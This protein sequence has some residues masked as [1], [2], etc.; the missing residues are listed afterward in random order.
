MSDEHGA[1]DGSLLPKGYSAADDYAQQAWAEAQAA[2]QVDWERRLLRRGGKDEG[3]IETA[4]QNAYLILRYDKAWQG[5]IALDEF[6]QRTIK[7]RPP[8]YE[9]AG[10]GEW[11][12]IDDSRTRVWL[13]ERYRVDFPTTTVAE[14]VSVVGFHNQFHPVREY[15]DGCVERWDGAEGRLDFWLSAYLGVAPPSCSTP[16]QRQYMQ[17]VGR[18]W[19]LSAVARIYQPGCKADHVLILEGPQGL[20][21]SSALRTLFGSWFLDT[22]INLND[23]DAYQAVQGRWGVELAELDSLN[24]VDATRAKSFFSSSEDYFRPSYGRRAQ[25]FPR[26]CVFAGSTNQNEYL[27]DSTGN[28]RFWPVLC[29][30]IDLGELERDRDHLWAEA[31]LAYRADASWWPEPAD[32]ALF[33]RE[34]ELREI[35]DPWTAVLAAWLESCT[36]SRVTMRECFEE[37]SI[38]PERQDER[39]MAMRIGKCMRKLGWHKVEARSREERAQS[40]FYYLRPQEGGD[41]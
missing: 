5:V 31:V 29:A 19:L 6:S 20:G 35:E 34:Q 27:R 7:R 32:H 40:R 37:L 25:A 39:A 1:G 21:K 28:R 17:R 24:K 38:R 23:K 13:A 9:P 30:R 41:G 12:N 2:T 33:D 16:E 36:L 22:P 10:D 14:A 26:Q 15:L 8:P 3:P 18:L 4:L 11:T